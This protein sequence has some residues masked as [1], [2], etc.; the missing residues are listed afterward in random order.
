MDQ[1]DPDA[2]FLAIPQEVRDEWEAAAGNYKSILN[3]V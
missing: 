3:G 1:T 2:F